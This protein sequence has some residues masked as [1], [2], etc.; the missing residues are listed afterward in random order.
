MTELHIYLSKKEKALACRDPCSFSFFG[1]HGIASN[2]CHE[3]AACGSPI[4]FKKPSAMVFYYCRN[5]LQTCYG[6]SGRKGEN[7]PAIWWQAGLGWEHQVSF[8]QPNTP[9]P[10]KSDRFHV[11]AVLSAVCR[12]LSGLGVLGGKRP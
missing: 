10:L 6:P 7:L 8:W 12:C 3:A 4:F 1:A 2:Y 9:Q 5:K 11:L